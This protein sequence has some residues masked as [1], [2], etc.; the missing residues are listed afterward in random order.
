L[1]IAPAPGDPKLSAYRIYELDGDGRFS[2]AD[3]I[4]AG[5]DEAALIAARDR[6]PSGPFELW[7]GRRLVARIDG[8]DERRSG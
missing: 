8:N 3:W 2:T 5:D 1:R 7:Q 4:E 6:F